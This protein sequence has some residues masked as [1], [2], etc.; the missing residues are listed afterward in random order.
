MKSAPLALSRDPISSL[1][2]KIALPAGVGMFFNTLFNFVDTYFAGLLGTDVLA[3]LTLS[4]APFFLLIAVGSGLSQGAAALMANALGANK[5]GSARRLFAQS[6]LLA[7][8]VGMVLSLVG[9]VTA[10]SLFRVLGAEGD[11]LLTTLSYM[12]IILLGCPLL[13]LTMAINSVLAAQG[14][15]RPYRNFLIFG[16]VANCLLNPLFMWG[17]PGIPGLGVAGI[18][19]AT[20]VIQLGGCIYLW[21][22]ASKV[23]FLRSFSLPL[24]RPD[25]Q[26]LRQLARQSIPAAL[27]MMT[28][29]VGIFVFTWFVQQFGREAV[30]ATGIAVRIEQI[31]LMPVIG[32][33]SALISLVAH[34]HGAG[35]PARVREAWLTNVKSGIGLMLLGG[36]LL[37]F[38]GQTLMH[39]FS[40]DPTVIAHGRQ[41][42][43][44]AAFTL[45]AYPIL[46][47]TVFMMQGLKR[48]IFGLL[49]GVY[50]QIAAPLLLCHALA[51]T[52]GWGLLGVWWGITLVTWSAALFALGWAWKT[53]RSHV[54]EMPPHATALFP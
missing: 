47:A 23:K 38:F 1:T 6:L 33:S 3:A 50:R 13:L 31:I 26:L 52:L 25:W 21:H 12:N 42:L 44:F 41:Y 29:A 20:V 54:S 32:L 19:L 28:I 48:P 34:N 17:L 7:A 37:G 8:Q 45:A 43:L 10:P 30:A 36:L 2:W 40:S 9:L 16:F 49:L 27:N 11:Y 39:L 35:L 51:I 46:F 53:L 24:L 5:A 14:E 22:K 15:N 18:A 4:F